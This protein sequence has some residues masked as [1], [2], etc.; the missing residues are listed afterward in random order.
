MLDRKKAHTNHVLSLSPLKK[1]KFLT[2]TRFENASLKYVLF[3]ILKHQKIW[4]GLNIF[5]KK[6]WCYETAVGMLTKEILIKALFK[7]KFLY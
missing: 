4:K 6:F 3:T 7:Q 5:S 1:L 2:K